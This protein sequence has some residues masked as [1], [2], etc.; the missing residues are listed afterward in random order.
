MASLELLSTHLLSRSWHSSRVP[1][2]L[3][4]HVGKGGVGRV[5]DTWFSQNRNRGEMEQNRGKH[6]EIQNQEILAWVDSSRPLSQQ[7]AL[8]KISR[9]TLLS[10]VMI[11]ICIPD[12]MLVTCSKVSHLTGYFAR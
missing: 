1:G 9:A 3:D 8:S 6:W 2:G 4:G 12:N 5:Q 11:I 10:N 7:W